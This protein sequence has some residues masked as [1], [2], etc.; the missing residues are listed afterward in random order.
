MRGF[1]SIILILAAGAVFYFGV[2]PLYQSAKLLKAESTQYSEALNNS[3]ALRQVR[4]NLVAKYNAFDKASIDRLQKLLP[5]SV[6]NIRLI[7]DM[8]GIAAKYGMSLKNIK[9][10]QLQTI[11]STPGTGA[12]PVGSI[13]LS[14]S[15]ISPYENLQPFL[16]DLE[17]SLRL[18]D[19]T[20]LSFTPNDQTGTYAYNVTLQT[21]WLK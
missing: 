5:D 17:S 6:D 9:I 2:D 12:N 15:V 20:N 11:N 3:S 8:N 14:F 19:V 4:N 16:K 1:I 18:V 7:L 21:Y 10:S 13:Q